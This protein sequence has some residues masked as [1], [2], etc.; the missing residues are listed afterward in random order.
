MAAESHALSSS[1]RAVPPD[2]TLVRAR[3]MARALGIT[4]VTD[5]TR[6][7]RVGIPVF[8]SIRPSAAEGSICVNAGKGLRPIEAE[9]GAYMEAIE[10]ALAEPGM[11]RVEV[12]RATARDVLDGRRRPE[13]VLDLC[14]KIGARVTLDAPMDCVEVEELASGARAL[15]PAE[16][17]F[18]P[19]RPRPRYRALFGTTSNG[20]ASGNTVREATVHGL[21]ELVERDVRAFESVRDTSVPVDLDT[22]EGDAR[23]LVDTVREAGLELYVRAVENPYGLAY[24]TAV[25]ND[26]DAC[27]PQLL[28]GGYGCHPHRAI[29]FVRAV[30]EAAQSRLSFIHGG[31]DDLVAHYGHFAGWSTGRKRAHVRR[32]VAMAREGKKVPLARIADHSRVATGIE[33]CEELVLRQLATTGLERAYR[34]VLTRRNDPLQVVRVIVPRMEIFSSMTMRVGPRLRDHARAA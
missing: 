4:R 27:M 29:A 8:A 19:Y 20:L 22:A 25:I 26:P 5:I 33:A 15:V 30:C 13:A 31:R 1:L 18:L 32:I 10:F 28:N 16:I 14:P 3:Q 21:C 34:A 2:V 7:D 23:T 17:V 9:V 12:V 24:F 11:S 6:L